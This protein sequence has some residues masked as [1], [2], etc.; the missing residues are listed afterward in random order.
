MKPSPL[1]HEALFLLAY[2]EIKLIFSQ[3]I[4]HCYTNKLETIR[5]MV[6]AW[7][8]TSQAVAWTYLTVCFSRI[9]VR[10]KNPCNGCNEYIETFFVRNSRLLL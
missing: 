9:F 2:L 5:V 8:C 3:K 1:I 6:Y 7:M 10:K 4:S